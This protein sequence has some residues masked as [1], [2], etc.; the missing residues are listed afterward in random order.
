MRVLIAGAGIGGLTTA[1]AL[2]A[3]GIDVRVFESVRE[4]APLGVGINLLPHATAELAAL[5]V[6]EPID[7]AG[8]RTAELCYYNRHGQLI[9]REPRGLDAGYPV[10]QISIHRGALQLALLAIVTLVIKTFV[11]WRAD[12][13]TG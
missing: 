12:R 3:R 11:E 4:L 2:H 6:L 9:W 8:V 13:R 7:A 10:P 1:L 5:G